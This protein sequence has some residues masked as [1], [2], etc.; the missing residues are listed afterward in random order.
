[1]KLRFLPQE[2]LKLLACVI[3]FLDHFAY[4]GFA[5]SY[6]TE[7]RVIGRIAFPIFCFL[8]CQGF[9]HTRSREKYVLRLAIGAVL[10]EIPFNLMKT[11]EFF[12]L[13]HQSVMVTLLLAFAMAYLM[14]K[15][16]NQ[17]LKLLLLPVFCFLAD[18]I[19]TDYAA[20]GVLMVAVFLFTEKLPVKI[21]VKLLLQTALLIIPQLLMGGKKLDIMGI[22]VP[23]QLFAV[24]AM[25]PIALY[26]GKKLTRC[27]AVQWGFYLFYPVHI[28]ILALFR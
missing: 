1:M 3:M 27:K 6:A 7:F 14:E 24:F 18:V 16:P 25:V 11:G 28:L 5:G 15:T 19:N 22:H 23:M 10:S 8:L 2:V 26:S 21:P 13:G 4:L 20:A 12:S 9:M 17:L